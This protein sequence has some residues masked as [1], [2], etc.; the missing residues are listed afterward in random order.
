MVVDVNT[1]DVV[2]KIDFDEYGNVLFNSN[3]GFIPFGFAGGLY[4]RE[5]KLVRFG[6]RDY[7]PETGRWTAKD[8]IGF[9]GGDAN[10]YMYV[11]NDPLIYKDPNG[12]IGI[13]VAGIIWGLSALTGGYVGYKID[14]A[15][16]NFIN[17]ANQK[18]NT[19]V[20]W[21]NDIQNVEKQQARD[22]ALKEA[23]IAGVE[24]LGATPGLSMTSPVGAPIS[25]P[26]AALEIVQHA[27]ALK[28]GEEKRTPC[29]KK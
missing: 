10:L 13:I 9:N 25:P 8:P 16:N 29:S 3:P 28:A 7:D 18:Y 5:V 4:D 11:R 23:P 15:W 12:K 27:A 17:K 6:A 22:Q 21:L 1:G 14:E 2:D 24:A 20:N 19:E 26:E